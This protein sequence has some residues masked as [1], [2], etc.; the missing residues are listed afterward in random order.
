MTLFE[1]E[2][3]SYPADAFKEVVYFCSSEGACNLEKIPS[4]QINRMQAIL[5]EHGQ[6]GWELVHVAFGKDG[7]LAFWKRMIKDNGGRGGA[8][9][10]E[11]L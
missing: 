11:V 3:T 10:I 1:Y 2:I 4:N 6:E 7:I 5:N 8:K 9:K